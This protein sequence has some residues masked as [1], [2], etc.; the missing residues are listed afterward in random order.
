ML[1]CPF[2][3]EG[4]MAGKDIIMLSQKELKRI[5]IIQKV[6]DGVIKQVDAAGIL[7]LSTR[8]IRRIVKKVKAEGEKGIIHK[9]RGRDSNRKT[10]KKIRDRVVKLYR[11]R[12]KDFGPT[13]AS[14]KLFERDGIKLNDETLRTWLIESGDW[15]KTRKR[16]VYHQWRER[17]Q[18]RG[19]MVQMDGSH[20]DWLEGR[21]PRCVL[22]GYIDDATG[23][24]FGRFYE[25]EGTIPAMDSF[26]RYIKRHGIPMSVYLDKHT[27]Y[28]STGKPTLEDELNDTKPLSEFERAL[29]ELGV[30]VIHANSPQAKGRVERLFGTLQDR[31]VKEMRLKNVRTIQEANIFLAQY[32]PSYNK[33]FAVIPLRKE[34]LHRDISTGLNLNDIFC[35]KTKRTLR[36]DFTIAHN[37]KLYQIQSHIHDLEVIIHDRMDGSMIVTHNGRPIQFAEIAARPVKEKKPLKIHRK[38]YHPT[39]YDSWKNFKFGVH[40][41]EQ[42]HF[43]GSK[44]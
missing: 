21:G 41:Y 20:H 28:K 10:P 3:K 40:R 5:H 4:T 12:Y 2:P 38:I 9:S 7:L 14:E 32:L 30:E 18:Y 24:T 36:N 25:Y 42:G 6:A 22:M 37:R 31:L 16:R 27:T 26:K 33:R 19:E 8:Q 15:K 23:T 1:N 35:V 43:I 11:T 17:K 29:K 39:K 44:P 34:N 13:L